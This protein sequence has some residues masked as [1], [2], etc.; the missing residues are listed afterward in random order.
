MK[1]EQSINEF[2]TTKLFAEDV[3]TIREISCNV[4]LNVIKEVR[5]AV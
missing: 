2:T 1:R 4:E 3:E 5:E